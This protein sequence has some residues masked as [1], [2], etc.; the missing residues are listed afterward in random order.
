[1][2]IERRNAGFRTNK[3]N[4][5]N[6]LIGSGQ[7]FRNKEID[8]LHSVVIIFTAGDARPRGHT[9]PSDNPCEAEVVYHEGLG[10]EHTLD[11]DHMEKKYWSH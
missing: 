8:N 9:A 7:I 6:R 1:M 2:L 4:R 10:S 5:L 3:I 11:L